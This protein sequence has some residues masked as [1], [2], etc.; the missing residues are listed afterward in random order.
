LG[1][2]SDDTELLD[3]TNGSKEVFQSFLN[4]WVYGIK[5]ANARLDLDWR[6]APLD[7][8]TETE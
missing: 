7:D 4:D 2:A 5:D 8:Y 3:K 6:F 1:Y